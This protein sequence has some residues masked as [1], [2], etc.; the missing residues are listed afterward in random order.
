[1]V[2]LI[3]GLS[4]CFIRGRTATQQALKNYYRRSSAF[5][6]TA[7]TRGLLRGLPENLDEYERTAGTSVLVNSGALLPGSDSTQ[8]PIPPTESRSA[9]NGTVSDRKT[10]SINGMGG[11]AKTTGPEC[12]RPSSRSP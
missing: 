9:M 7:R 6:S 2:K 12:L 5:G 4:T 8:A 1:M 3:L 10:H 11:S